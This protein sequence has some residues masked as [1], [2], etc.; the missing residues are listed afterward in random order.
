MKENE[1]NMYKFSKSTSYDL[2]ENG[3]TVIG[4]YQEIQF[5]DKGLKAITTV[6]HQQMYRH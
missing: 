4:D 3:A 5:I 2:Y 1:I 6:Y